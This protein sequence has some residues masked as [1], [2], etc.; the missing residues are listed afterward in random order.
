MTLTE[1][2]SGFHS[3]KVYANDTSGNIGVSKSFDFTVAEN[4][5]S[6]LLKLL[7]IFLIVAVTVAAVVAVGVL[8]YRTKHRREVAQ[9]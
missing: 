6:Q 1:L 8:V 7:P 3:L 4:G 2:S 5:E 9:A